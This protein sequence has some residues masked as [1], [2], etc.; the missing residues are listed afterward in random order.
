M[1]VTEARLT[2]CIDVQWDTNSPTHIIWRFG[3]SFQI[4]DYRAAF[5]RTAHLIELVTHPVTVVM[6]TRRCPSTT[7]NIIPVVRDHLH[8]MQ[9]FNGEVVILARSPFWQR[10]Y[11]IVLYGTHG[12]RRPS[13]RFLITADETSDWASLVS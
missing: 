9:T 8:K 11:Q 2:M 12:L 1:L 5:R 10:I 4:D 13:V 7:Q 3:H 6:D